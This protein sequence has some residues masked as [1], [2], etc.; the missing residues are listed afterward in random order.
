MELGL[1]EPEVTAI[2]KKY[3]TI[4]KE[5]LTFQPSKEK[6]LKE[7]TKELLSKYGNNQNYP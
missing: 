6:T 7:R 3:I 2:I 1:E 5:I 4:Y